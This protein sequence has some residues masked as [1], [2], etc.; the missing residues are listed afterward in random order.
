MIPIAC[1]TRTA[2]SA[3]Q[4]MIRP[5]LS[6]FIA[7]FSATTAMA[8]GLRVASFNIGAHFGE[9]YFDYSLGDPG[10]PDHDT[11]RD[12]LFRLDADV[13]A[14]Q[15]IHTAD[16]QDSPTDLAALA[17][18]LGYPYVHVPPVTG[19][20]DTSLRVVFLSRFPF[21][22]AAHIGSPPAAKELTR[23]HPL[24]KVD[25]PET[26][27]DPVLISAHLKAETGLAERFRR[28]LEM[29]RLVGYLSSAGLTNADNF[30]ILGDFNPSSV[31][32][33][34][35]ELP[36]GLPSTFALGADIAFPVTYSI[37]P[38]DYFSTP[39][40]VNADPRQLDGSRS[41]Y[42]TGAPGGPALD[43]I[44]LSPAIAGRRFAAEI[45]NS[46][47]DVSNSSGLP[48]A[49]S[50]PAADTSA[51][52]SDHYAVFADLELDSVESYVFTAPGQTM[53]ENFDGFTGVRDPAPW[54]TS[55]GTAWRGPDDGS[56][57]VPGWRA[58]GSAGDP[59]PG[60]LSDGSAA[61]VIARYDNRSSV[62]LTALE[63][64]MDVGQWRAVTNGAADALGAEILIGGQSIPLPSLDFT[65]S[66]SLPTGPVPGG[67]IT[68]LSSM[69]DS[70]WI[71]PGGSFELR[72][73]FQPGAGGGPQP[74]DVFVN[75]FHYDNDG[76]DSGEF[77]EIAVSPG[78]SGNPSDVSLV[79][80]NG[81][82]GAGYGTHTLDSFTP[83]V[84]TAS[85]HRLFHK[86]IGGL[87]NGAPD[88]FAV[89]AG[90]SVLHF[91][92]YEGA[93]TATDGPA[94]GMTSTN[95]DISQTGSEPIGESALG[96]TGTGTLAADF[97]WRKFA[98]IAHS[99]GQANDGQAFSAA[100]SAPQGLGFDA[101]AVSFLTDNELDGLPDAADPDDDNDGQADAHEAAFGTDPLD[102]AS[103]FVPV[104]ARAAEP[105]HGLELSFP[106]ASGIR[107]TVESS[108]SLADWRNLSTHTGEGRAVVVPLPMAEPRMFFRVR[109]GGP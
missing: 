34:F 19:V 97:T 55:G 44:L 61:A 109:A 106:G 31:N 12:I 38:L 99:P 63:I 66:R 35:T 74:S 81:A 91:I 47:L 95:I 37:N 90:S 73:S 108:D 82:G 10:T 65:A 53:V 26:V 56:S 52:A 75:E 79:L 5:L 6:V 89:V 77:V 18:S 9:T 93:F 40:A 15:E 57:T 8:V 105:P 16:L 84:T 59:A 45:Y 85:G 25:V 1:R 24:V 107:Y 102:A 78:F 27:N 92:S 69:A 33:T 48:K 42:D 58:Y 72:I 83:G 104:L 17:A 98:G 32:A 29:K 76:T 21:L 64:A 62:P 70:L 94:A 36:A 71:P 80:Y 11:V 67:A 7:I 20:F 50:P 23:L 86:L 87:Q 14:L 2:M 103:R 39:G 101:V 22:S 54:F 30:V 68:R 96:L 41:T 46:A 60:F 4:R 28:A 49:G 3:P 13:V 43:L 88:G 51:T 100:A